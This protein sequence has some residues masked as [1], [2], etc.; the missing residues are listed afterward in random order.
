[1]VDHDDIGSPISVTVYGGFY[2]LGMAYPFS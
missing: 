2:E 1:M